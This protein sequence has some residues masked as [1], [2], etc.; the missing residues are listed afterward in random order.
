MLATAIVGQE[1]RYTA[2]TPSKLGMSPAAHRLPRPN[3]VTLFDINRILQPLRLRTSLNNSYEILQNCVG[4]A[5]SIRAIN[6][7]IL[8]EFFSFFDDRL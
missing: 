1:S 7:W 2:D 6:Y 8:S 4:G 5:K 3:R